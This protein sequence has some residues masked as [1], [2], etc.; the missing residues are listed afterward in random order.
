MMLIGHR[1]DEAFVADD[2]DDSREP[3][4][5][6]RPLPRQQDSFPAERVPLCACFFGHAACLKRARVKTKQVKSS[7]MSNHAVTGFMSW[8]LVAVPFATLAAACGSDEAPQNGNSV[9]AT[10]GHETGGANTGGKQTGGGGSG[11]R[12]TS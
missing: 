9:G 1:T 12:G 6:R 11:G 3:T 2:G 5:S 8:A 10:G 7:N 4:C